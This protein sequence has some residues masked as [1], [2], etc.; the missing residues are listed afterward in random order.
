MW[1][2]VFWRQKTEMED[3]A[4]DYDSDES[5]GFGVEL[6]EGSDTSDPNK[7]APV[8]PQMMF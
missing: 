2:S 5:E 3:S 8:S 1:Q 7:P 6:G 4:D